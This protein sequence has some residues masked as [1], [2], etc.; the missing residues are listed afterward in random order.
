MR[1]EFPYLISSLRKDSL[2]HEGKG[3][4]IYLY[5]KYRILRILQPAIVYNWSKSNLRI[6]YVQIYLHML[7]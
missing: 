5:L 6:M 7:R 2:K 1:Q 4:S 3:R